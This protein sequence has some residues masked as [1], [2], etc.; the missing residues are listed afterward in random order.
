MAT[1]TLEEDNSRHSL[2]EYNIHIKT[3]FLL[4]S[5][6]YLNLRD[7]LQGSTHIKVIWTSPE[8]EGFKCEPQI[9]VTEFRSQMGMEARLE[10]GSYSTENSNKY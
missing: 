7:I 4:K 6:L 10:L 5:N 2:M 3:F 1:S 8:S 9:A